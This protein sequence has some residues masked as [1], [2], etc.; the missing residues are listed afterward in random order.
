MSR[1]TDVH[2]TVVPTTLRTEASPCQTRSR[3]QDQT[4]RP[5]TP[6]AAVTPVVTAEQQPLLPEVQFPQ[7]RRVPP[8]VRLN[9]FAREFVPL[10]ER[11]SLDVEEPASLPYSFEATFHAHDSY[12]YLVEFRSS[13]SV[14]VTLPDRENRG[15]VSTME[16]TVYDDSFLDL[17]RIYETV[18]EF[19][20]NFEE[21]EEEENA[22]QSF[23]EEHTAQHALKLTPLDAARVDLFR[24]FDYQHR[25]RKADGDKCSI[26]QF[27][28]ALEDPVMELDCEHRFHE[29][30]ARDAFAR[31]AKCA[32]CRRCYLEHD[33]VLAGCDK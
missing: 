12:Y 21:D 11:T 24:S 32:N 15:E 17:D 28:F 1:Q 19:I 25:D 7:E 10:R 18:Q 30:C 27:E 33:H 20:R 8:P 26:C 14:T 23:Y 4:V 2:N 6:V 31:S 22:L 9:V 3:P 29:T 16:Y 5:P 13:S